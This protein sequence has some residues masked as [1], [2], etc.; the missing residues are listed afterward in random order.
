[1]HRRIDKDRESEVVMDDGRLL[2]ERERE[3]RVIFEISSHHWNFFPP[4]MH[5]W[6]CVDSFRVSCR[7]LQNTDRMRCLAVSIYS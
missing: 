3:M 7:S 6:E 1:M 2:R 5:L 4:S